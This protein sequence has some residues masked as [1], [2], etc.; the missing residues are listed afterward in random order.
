MDLNELS[1]IDEHCHPFTNEHNQLT[2]QQ[3][4]DIIMFKLEGGA[5]PHAE[6]T[7][8]AHLFLREMAGLLGCQATLQDV[9]NERNKQASTDYPAFVD[10]VLGAARITTL[11]PDT[12][13]PYWKKVTVADCAQVV[14]SRSLY[15]VFRAE[16][17]FSSRNGIYMQDRS[18]NFDD[19]LQ[20]Y[21]AACVGAVKTR[22]CVGIKT[23]IAYRTGLAIQP[24]NYDQAQ[25][26]FGAN[27]DVDLRAQKMVRDYLFKFTARLAAE[28]EVPFV[29]HTG[30]TA[31]TKPW[32]YGNPTEL[33]PAI[34]DPELQETTFVLLHG[35]YPWCSA[36]GYIA[37][38]HPNVYVDLSEFNPASSIGV[39]RHFEEILEF[40][41]L[42]KL[43]FGSDGLGIPE[44]N[45]YG[46]VL[47]KRALGNILGRLVQDK[48][49]RPEQ[50]EHFA[51]DI[52]Y[53]TAMKVYALA[54][55]P[56]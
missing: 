41:P 24:V 35:G 7:L 19:Y 43:M 11:L 50:A 6:D 27:T 39:E 54:G 45:W 37:S 34:T 52:F 56:K 20:A 44:L 33:V 17:A 53:N 25:T 16:S 55:R 21:R 4:R 3:L 30:F 18:L 38:H 36:A 31:L 26:A 15:E 32:S 12:G 1:V 22:G 13:Y 29:I 14:T 5:P 51:E 8:T 10:R 42:T 23:V 9:L 40:A 2:E 48:L 49:I 46:A 47:A 28:L